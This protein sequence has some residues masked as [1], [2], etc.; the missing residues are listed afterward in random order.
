[1]NYNKE[2]NEILRLAGVQLNEAYK[3]K[4]TYGILTFNDLKEYKQLGK[5]FSPMD[6]DFRADT[7]NAKDAKSVIMD[8]YDD[9]DICQIYRYEEKYD[10]K[11]YDL[12]STNP[13]LIFSA[14]TPSE[15]K[16]KNIL[17]LIK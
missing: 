4:N 2:I 16:I 6:F 9:G 1:M 17:K 14:K 7:L 8:Y 12:I 11:E 10:E 5:N 3:P 15:S 13:Q